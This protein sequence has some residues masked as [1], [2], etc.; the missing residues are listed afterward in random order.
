MKKIGRNDPCSCG[1]GLKFKKCCGKSNVI[2]FTPLRLEKE[3]EE[4]SQ[5]L[6]DFALNNYENVIG[7]ITLDLIEMNLTENTADSDK[8]SYVS[9]LLTWLIINEP[10][11]N[12]QTILAVF[13][14]R[15]MSGIK[16]TR[17]KQ[18]FA[19]WEAAKSSI[20]EIVSV[21]KINEENILIREV[22]SDETYTVMH[23]GIKQSNIGDFIIGTL[24]PFIQSH[25]FI[26][27]TVS[28]SQEGRDFIY[29]VLDDFSLNQEIIHALFPEWLGNIM[30]PPEDELEWLDP[31]YKEV[32]MQFAYHM[33]RK[34]VDEDT[35]LNGIVYWNKYCLKHQPYV[36]K[37]S[38]YAAALDY[39]INLLLLPENYV[40]QAALA[41]EYKVSAGTISTHYQKFIR[42]FEQVSNNVQVDNPVQSIPNSPFGME[43]EMNN[44]QKIINDQDFES[45]EELKIFLDEL[46]EQGTIDDMTNDSPGD[47]AQDL[48]YQAGDK[49]GRERKKI[50][51][52]A[53][54]LDPSN[55]DAYVLLAADEGNLKKRSDLLNKAITIGEK[56]LGPK[57]FKENKGHFW[58]IFETRPYMR[59]K[60]SL[61]YLLESTGKKAEAMK[62]YEELLELNSSDNLGIRYILLP[63]YI[64][65]KMYEETLDLIE[66]YEEYPSTDILYSHTLVSFLIHGNTKGTRDLLN[67][68]MEHN[69]YVIDY[70]SGRKDIP[71]E[72]YPYVK[73]RGETEAIVY[74]QRNASLWIDAIELFEEK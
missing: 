54:E 32:A 72:S 42:E 69:Q 19:S 53:L 15:K 16:N 5:E 48:I 57:F 50:I 7:D 65:L 9:L 41:K 10:I 35:I 22:V 39:F 34:G 45:E 14:K 37:A 17:V 18:A 12:D 40:T 20:F 26:F 73:F 21:D 6:V 68:A 61:G 28:I 25:Y 30:A 36:T 44:L 64:E 63:L 52:Q 13:S 58:G 29:D 46:L 4:L 38:T 8:E 55:L 24:L 33:D 56:E 2:P 31:L 3:L 47:K 59:A 49:Q 11:D 71:V 51:D 23:R 1:S 43:K 67:K 70:L 60:Q 66:E 27:S 62:I 74:A